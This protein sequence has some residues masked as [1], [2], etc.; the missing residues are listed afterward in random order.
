MKYQVML[1]ILFLLLARKRVSAKYIADRYEISIRTVYRYI[2]ELSLA[3]VPIYNERGRN[4][5]YSI[6]ENFKISANYLTNEESE[7]IISALI[8]INKELGSEV[9][10]GAIDKL[11]SISK[12]SNETPTINFGNLVID[13]SAWGVNDSYSETLKLL[14]KAIEEKT[15]LSVS[16]VDRDG[17]VS[18]RNIEPHVLALKQGL[19]YV[20]AYCRLR[21]TFR[22]FKV[23]RIQKIKN[24]S[25]SFTRRD[26]LDMKSVFEKWYDEVDEDIDLIIDKSVKADVEE[27]L[28]VDK[29]HVSPSGKITA[30]TKLPIDDYLTA[31]ILSF[32]SKVKVENPKKLKDAVIK[33]AKS[34]ENLYN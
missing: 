20:Y 26:L 25:E 1:K 7:Q 17:N 23:G 6:S 9:M 21:N 31:K 5:G 30:S 8:E 10:R 12:T 22:L 2:D 18:E 24:L 29:V 32:G 14:Q 11:S 3:G 13:G 27:W 28:G 16:Y 34:V 4:G 19:W 15:L 33:T